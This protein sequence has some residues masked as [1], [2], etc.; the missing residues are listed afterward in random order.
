[1]QGGCMVFSIYA[2]QQAGYIFRMVEFRC[3]C[4][5]VTALAKSKIVPFVEFCAYLER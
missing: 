2:L 4:D 5:D 3:Q 1:M